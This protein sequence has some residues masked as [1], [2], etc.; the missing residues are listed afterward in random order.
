MGRMGDFPSS[1]G[2]STLMISARKSPRSM[3]QKGPARAPVKSRVLIHSRGP[4]MKN[5]LLVLQDENMALLTLRVSAFR[6]IPGIR[7]PC[8]TL[9]YVSTKGDETSRIQGPVFVFG[10][11]RP[12][13]GTACRGRFGRLFT[14][15]RQGSSSPKKK[16]F[17]RF[18]NVNHILIKC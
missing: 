11:I 10:H 6:F 2:F 4:A 3:V 5:H 14:D 1:L 13:G 17:Y 7:N 15:M 12:R 8:P 18:H 9:I 16:K